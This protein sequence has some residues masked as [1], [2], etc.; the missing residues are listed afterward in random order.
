MNLYIDSS[1]NRKTVIRLDTREYVFEYASPR[2]Q[3]VLK[4]VM[5]SIEAEKKA[6]TDLTSITVVEGPGSFTGLRVGLSIAN[7][8]SFALSIPING[9]EAGTTIMPKYGAEPS[10]NHKTP[11]K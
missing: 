9:Q 11:K 2:S 1:N 5:D 8:L 4:A 10:I 3:N 7:A 6:L